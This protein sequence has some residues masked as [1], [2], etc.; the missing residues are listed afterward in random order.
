MDDAGRPPTPRSPS[1]GTRPAPGG[2]RRRRTKRRRSRSCRGSR[3]RALADAPGAPPAPPAALTRLYL[4][5]RRLRLP[6]VSAAASPRC[7]MI[8]SGIG[9]VAV[10]S[11]VTL[12]H[13]TE[14][15]DFCG[16]CHTMGP[17]LKAYHAGPHRDVACGECHVEPG[18]TGWVKAK[19]NGTR[20]LVEV[21]LGTF[22]KPIPPPEHADLPD[23]ADTCMKCHDVS[24]EELADLRTRTAF[25]EDEDNTRQF[26][27]L[28]I[29][30][31]S[32]DVFDVD[33][34]VHW[35][36]VRHV[37]FYSP[38]AHKLNIDLV[39][40]TTPDGAIEQY[41]SQDKI[42]VAD[43]VQP[44]I[45]AI[46]STQTQTTMSCYD[47]HNRIGHAV[48]NPR[49]GLDYK[50]STGAIDSTLPYIKREGMRILWSGYPDQASAG[51]RGRQARRLLRA[52]LP[53][54][55]RHEGRADRRGRRRDQG[56]L[57]ADG[58]T[59]DEGHRGHVSRQ[60]GPQ[61]LPGLLPVPRRRPLPGQGRR[62]AQEDDPL[63]L[64]HLPH[65]P[66]DRAGRRQPAARRAA[67]HAR[68]LAVGV[69]P[70]G[71]GDGPRPRRA[72]LRG[73]PCARLLRELPRH[74]APSPSTTTRWRPT[75][76][77]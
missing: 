25:S 70:Q 36:V 16:R 56:P 77:R 72:D 66:A 7:C 76:P 35:H 45:D 11:T 50:L 18:V 37:D 75:T 46:K 47:C 64:R 51:C 58:D 52:E 39:E 9:L 28:M 2:R 73:V 55:R 44:D 21:V 60:H 22:P 24:S 53:G 57:P 12:I 38:D 30:P 14:T 4:R 5:G 20:Q 67:E 33:R 32:G 1:T 54:D 48:S 65:V 71:R 68:R 41:I 3:S 15:A 43:D 10:F 26:V 19:I 13:W 59:R 34:G 23:P 63:E 17:E 62:R 6:A 49:V 29:R 27:G 42:T 8:A 61:R 31:G 74:R 69:Q 40:A